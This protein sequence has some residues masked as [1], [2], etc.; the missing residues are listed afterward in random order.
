MPRT[1]WFE[2]RV[3]ALNAHATIIPPPGDG[4]APVVVQFHGCGG[5]K[6]FQDVWA[7]KFAQM[8]AGAVIVDS[9]APRGV[10]TAEAYATICTG[11][12]FWGRERAGDV[13]AGLAIA[14]DLPFADP[15]RLFLAGWSHGGW[16]VLDAMA[17]RPGAEIERATGLRDVPDEPLEGLGGALL[18]YPY[19]GRAAVARR[20]LRHGAPVSAILGGK[21]SIVGAREPSRVLGALAQS[22]APIATHL[23]ETATHA[24]DEADARD[25]RVC[26]D[27]DLVDRAEALARDFLFGAR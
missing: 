20:G 12:R 22:G 4:P 15:A 5:R 25:A 16:A 6:R 2:E 21:D 8:G 10:S 1:Q 27:Q 17:L 14:R 19:C 24:F 3:A 13:F 7:E 9:Y 23:F 26:Y 18:F 11:L